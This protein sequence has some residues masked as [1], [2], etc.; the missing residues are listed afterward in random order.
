[1]TSSNYKYGDQDL[2]YVINS[3][4]TFTSSTPYINFPNSF[5]PGYANGSGIDLPLPF[6]YKVSGVDLSNTTQAH[7]QITFNPGTYNAISYSILNSSPTRYYKHISGYVYSGSGGGGGG[8]G[9]GTDNLA[10]GNHSKGG[11]GGNG[12]AGG[13]AAV[14]QYPIAGQVI[15]LIVGAGGTGGGG[16]AKSSNGSG[17]GGGA[18]TP[19]GLSSLKIGNTT[20]LQGAAGAYGNRGNGGSGNGSKGSDGT[21]NANTVNSIANGGKNRTTDPNV[22]AAPYWP[23]NG[24]VAGTGGAGANWPNSAN[25]GNAGNNGYASLRFLYDAN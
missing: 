4:G 16:G 9:A 14:V 17:Q 15:N 19:G 3:T 1:M 12:G 7:Q 5:P 22:P 24:A 23:P 11:T 25:P 10:G 13:Y 2:F 8:G 20:V 18:G 6:N 21:T